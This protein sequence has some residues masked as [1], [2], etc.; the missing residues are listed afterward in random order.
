MQL[1]FASINIKLPIALKYN[2]AA[3]E[4]LSA[5]LIFP[6]LALA[7]HYCNKNIWLGLG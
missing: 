3:F 6:R 7:F 5:F 2:K 1:V 4:Y